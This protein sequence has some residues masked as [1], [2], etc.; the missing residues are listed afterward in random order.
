L[1]ESKNIVA[2]KFWTRK[3]SPNIYELLTAIDLI[4]PK[5]NDNSLVFVCRELVAVVW[6]FRSGGLAAKVPDPHMRTNLTQ[7]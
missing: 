1:E 2:W 7:I 5:I 6:N 4:P 3:S